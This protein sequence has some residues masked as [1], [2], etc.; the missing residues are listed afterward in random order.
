MITENS[1]H[2]HEELLI[3]IARQLRLHAEPLLPRLLDNSLSNI[4]LRLIKRNNM[5]K[6]DLAIQ[7][8]LHSGSDVVRVVVLMV[9]VVTT[10]ADVLVVAV[11]HFMKLLL[12]IV[13]C[14]SGNVGFV[15]FAGSK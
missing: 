3:H 5:I 12:L 8:V 9:M 11:R 14:E 2:S 13:K 10:M 1:R 15:C 4:P 6:V 7:R